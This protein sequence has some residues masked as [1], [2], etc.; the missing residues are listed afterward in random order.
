MIF[1]FFNRYR[2]VCHPL[3]K[4]ISARLAKGLCVVCLVLSF[5]MSSPATILYD[6]QI[7]QTAYDNVTG[8]KCG[9]AS[10]FQ[11]KPFMAYFNAVYI[12]VCLVLFISMTIIYS[13]MCKVIRAHLSLRSESGVVHF[14]KEA[15]SI[16]SSEKSECAFTTSKEIRANRT[17]DKNFRN[18]TLG[19]SLNRPYR[20]H[21]SGTANRTSLMFLCITAIFFLSYIPHLLLKIVVFTVKDFYVDLSQTAQI[22]YNTFI[23][24]FFINNVANPVVFLIFDRTFRQ[25][26]KAF[27]K[28]VISCKFNKYALDIGDSNVES[29]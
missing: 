11:G 17:T 29:T 16:Q 13:F 27:Y 4:Q 18:R 9:E 24:C 19:S 15:D 5:V 28:R 14:M 1:I 2:K 7:V 3:K 10:V 21:T 6:R 22:M 25:N 23:W 12:F 20:D 8:V 26:L